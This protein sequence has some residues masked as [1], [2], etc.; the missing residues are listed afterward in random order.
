[1]ALN[2]RLMLRYQETY[3]RKDK[4]KDFRL[5]DGCGVCMKRMTCVQAPSECE[6][7]EPDY[8]EIYRV[9]IGIIAAQLDKRVMRAC[10]RNVDGNMDVRISLREEVGEVDMDGIVHGLA[11]NLTEAYAEKKMPAEVENVANKI[12]VRFE[13]VE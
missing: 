4:M 1:M 6:G 10:V 7:Y 11:H 12:R 5:P 13:V 8:I 9:C 2:L 3:L